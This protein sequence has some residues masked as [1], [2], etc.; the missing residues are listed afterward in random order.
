MSFA[1]LSSQVSDTDS[2]AGLFVKLRGESPKRKYRGL[3]EMSVVWHFQ[4]LLP[5]SLMN[6]HCKGTAASDHLL[7]VVHVRRHVLTA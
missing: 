2:L 6:R 3:Q 5:T 4:H 7:L 1:M